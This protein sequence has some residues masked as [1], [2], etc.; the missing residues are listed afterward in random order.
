[1]KQIFFVLAAAGC[2][3]PADVNLTCVL[4]RSNPDGGMVGVPLRTTDPEIAFSANLD[5]ISFGGTDC[6]TR[7]CVRDAA[8]QQAPGDGELALGYC[9][10]ACGPCPSGLRCRAPVLDEQTLGRLRASDPESYKRTFGE[11]TTPYFCAR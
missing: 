9:S 1:M 6:S 4:V 11:T 5:I 3:A 7:V 8:F 2:A 10:V